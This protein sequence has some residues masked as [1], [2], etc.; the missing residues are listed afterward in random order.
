MIATPELR[1]VQRWKP[2]NGYQEVVTT[3][4]VLQQKWCQQSPRYSW[5]D[6]GSDPD[7]FEWRDVPIE[8]E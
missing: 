5:Y 2:V 4:H 7:V 3:V 1:W 6:C 8:L